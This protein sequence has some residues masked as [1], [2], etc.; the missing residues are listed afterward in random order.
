MNRKQKQRAISAE[1]IALLADQG[2][3][4][5]RY[6]TNSGRMMQPPKQSPESSNKPQ[7][8]LQLKKI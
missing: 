5:S 7:N 4:V 2:K 6:F 3:N 1:E 8:R